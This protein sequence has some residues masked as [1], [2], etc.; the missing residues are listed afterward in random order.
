[1]HPTPHQMPSPILWSQSEYLQVNQ[2]HDA[3]FFRLMVDECTNPATVE[4][5][6]LFLSLD[7]K[8]I[9]C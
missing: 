3:P 9:T 8:W 4:E 2:L 1:M 5:L 7:G 6:S